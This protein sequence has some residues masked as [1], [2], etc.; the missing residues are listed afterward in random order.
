MNR[1]KYEKKKGHW[2]EKNIDPDID[3]NEE[4]K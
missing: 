4:T 1:N 3:F 2:S